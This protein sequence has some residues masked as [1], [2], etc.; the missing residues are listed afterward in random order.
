MTVRKETHFIVVHCSAT[1]P[2][3]DIGA[4]DIDRWHK[5]K[6]WKG[7][8]YHDVIRRNGSLEFGR[9]ENEVGAHAKGYNS[10]S[11]G[12]CLVGGLS[13][14]T[15][16]PENNFTKEQFKTL[17]RC[18]KFYKTLFPHAQIVGHNEL[19]SGKACPCFDVQVWLEHV[20]L[21]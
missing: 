6:G 15:W 16:K 7:I 4:A 17:A 20:G 2:N 12:I 5:E 19:D 3:M 13:Q 18:L 14:D 10:M 21:Q 8:G 9:E 1:R 11:V